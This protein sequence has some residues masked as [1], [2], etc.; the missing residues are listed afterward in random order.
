MA[1]R[2]SLA[3]QP[4]IVA[5]DQSYYR[6]LLERLNLFTE[7]AVVVAALARPHFKHVDRIVEVTE[8]T[9]TC[10]VILT[11]FT[12]LKEDIPFNGLDRHINT[13]HRKVLLHGLSD[14]Y[15]R[16]HIICQ[17]LNADRVGCAN[18]SPSNSKPAGRSSIAF[19]T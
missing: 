18:I 2:L 4:F 17:V 10:E 6:I 5:D 19:S 13:N 3:G 7:L 12:C 15:V 1:K 9:V 11:S 14:R 8:P 16:F